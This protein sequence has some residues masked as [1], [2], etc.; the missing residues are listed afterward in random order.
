MIAEL[1]IKLT[2]KIGERREAEFVLSLPDAPDRSDL[3][4]AP[5]SWV[6]PWTRTD[7][8]V[9]EIVMYDEGIPLVTDSHVRTAPSSHDLVDYMIDFESGVYCR[10]MRA[11][12]TAQD[13]IAAQAVRLQPLIK[14]GRVVLNHWMVR[15]CRWILMVP[16]HYPKTSL[17]LG[18]VYLASDFYL[19]GRLYSWARW[20][21][22]GQFEYQP[23]GGVTLIRNDER[24]ALVDG[25]ASLTSRIRLLLEPRLL[26]WANRERHRLLTTTAVEDTWL[27][28]QNRLRDILT[29]E[30]HGLDWFYGMMPSLGDIRALDAGELNSLLVRHLNAFVKAKADSHTP[31]T[32]AQ[33]TALRASVDLA[34]GTH[35]Q[36]QVSR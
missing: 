8:K 4:V 27:Q 16:Y 36:I 2:K 15:A 30:D 18:C 26:R 28:Y 1:F 13:L 21:L 33:I 29:A 31:L 24:Q 7:T 12:T 17:F 14:A 10:A 32:I 22:E 25:D 34:V 20:R 3:K 5:P 35:V 19:R 9:S 11:I 23:A 6:W